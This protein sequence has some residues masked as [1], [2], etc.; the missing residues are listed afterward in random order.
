MEPQEEE[1]AQFESE[2]SDQFVGM[3]LGEAYDILSILGQGGMGV[4]LKARHRL[5]DR[6]VAIKI[7]HAHLSSS[8]E[9]IKR[10]RQEAQVMSA[11]S[12][13]HLVRIYACSETPTGQPFLVM[14]YLEGESLAA[15]LHREGHIGFHRCID[16]FEQAADALAYA[17]G[18]GILHRDLK[19]GNIMLTGVAAGKDCIKIVD[20]GIAK[21][22]PDFASQA[23][24]LT[25]TGALIGSPLYMSPE[26]CRSEKLDGRSDIYSLG[27]VM[28]EA[29]SGHPP[30]SSD[31]PLSA[32]FEHINR[33]PEDFDSRLDIPEA[34]AAVVFKA[35]RKDVGDRYQSM[36]ELKD[37]LSSAATSTADFASA[38]PGKARGFARGSRSKARRSGKP[39]AGSKRLLLAAVASAAAAFAAVLSTLPEVKIEGMKLLIAIYQKQDSSDK[40]DL[41]DAWLSLARLYRQSGYYGQAESDFRK[42][43]SVVDDAGGADSE[44]AALIL[45]EMADML[46]EETNPSLSWQPYQD[47]C[48]I[49]AKLVSKDVD[50]AQKMRHVRRGLEIL[51]KANRGA[52]G[53]RVQVSQAFQVI[54]SLP[55]YQGDLRRASEYAR[56]WSD[57]TDKKCPGTVFQAAAL[58]CFG[59]LNLMQGNRALALPALLQA[60]QLCARAHITGNPAIDGFLSAALHELAACQMQERHYKEADRLFERAHKVFQQ[61]G[62]AGRI[63][64][65]DMLVGRGQVALAEGRQADAQAFFEKAMRL[66]NQPKSDPPPQATDILEALGQMYSS[67]KHF[68]QAD[69]TLQKALA[70]RNKF[71]QAEASSK[72]P[73]H[74]ALARLY[75]ALAWNFRDW[76][77]LPAEDACLGKCIALLDRNTCDRIVLASAWQARGDIRFLQGDRQEARKCYERARQVWEALGD[78]HQAN[79]AGAYL[80]LSRMAEEEGNIHE[81]ESQLGRALSVLKMSLGT[82]HPTYIDLSRHCDQL[83]QKSLQPSR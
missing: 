1:N 17:H 27:C 82:R 78:L 59:H 18:Q 65:A 36:S 63:R 7:L 70:M 30:F 3:T 76:G 20:F 32:M 35:L 31:S 77:N 71:L 39:F 9:R 25:S 26:Q 24:N 66:Y 4:V 57:F 14:D 6:I 16:I 46:A 15:V 45:E 8:Q 83:K 28:Y 13:P 60:R 22:L 55:L 5:L 48:A 42:A 52:E 79:M 74:I 75:A 58:A 49:L 2:R 23:Q 21:F 38:C 44:Q 29:L 53:D 10:F 11:L 80:Q 41:V 81:A 50:A 72:G 19:P 61:F 40:H 67:Q 64:E 33:Q 69:E 37:A 47:A 73:Q 51:I 34:L 43:L 68:V 62:K 54:V 56:E 12:H